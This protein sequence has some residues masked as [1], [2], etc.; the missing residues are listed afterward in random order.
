MMHLFINFVQIAHK[1][2]AR[3]I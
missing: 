2:T 3:N 1:D